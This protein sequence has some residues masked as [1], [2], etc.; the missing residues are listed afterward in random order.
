MCTGCLCGIILQGVVTYIPAVLTPA[1]GIK[2]GS[3]GQ[4]VKLEMIKRSRCPFALLN[5]LRS[6]WVLSYDSTYTPPTSGCQSR[7]KALLAVWSSDQGPKMG[8]IKFW[9]W[10][11][12]STSIAGIYVTTYPL[13][14]QNSPSRG[15]LS[16]VHWNDR[17]AWGLYEP[18]SILTH[19]LMHYCSVLYV[20]SFINKLDKGTY[21]IWYTELSTSIISVMIIT[22]SLILSTST[23]NS[24]T[25]VV[26]VY[27]CSKRIVWMVM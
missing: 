25:T 24:T 16:L 26:E 2:V 13:F 18:K 5:Q 4:A 17:T 14:W 9:S 15:S 27:W 19:F 21:V 20:R 1:T 22:S 12:V 23:Y 10:L 8:P 11:R 7:V 6:R 3:S